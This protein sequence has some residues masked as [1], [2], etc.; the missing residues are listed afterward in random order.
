M[1]DRTHTEWR[2][3]VEAAAREDCEQQ[4]IDWDHML[5][6]Y[7][8]VNKLMKDNNKGSL[9][10][11]SMISSFHDPVTGFYHTFQTMHLWQG[12]IRK[13][14]AVCVDEDDGHLFECLG[15]ITSGRRWLFMHEDIMLLLFTVLAMYDGPYKKIIELLYDG[16]NGKQPEK[17]S[18]DNKA[19]H[20]A[21]GYGIDIRHAISPDLRNAAAH[22]SF[23]PNPEEG[24][25]VIRFTDRRGK[26]EANCLYTRE[27]L[28]SI[29]TKMQDALWLLY[30]AVL[31]WW[32]VE[33]GPMRLFDDA[34][35]RAENGKD[36]RQAALASMMQPNNQNIEAWKDIVEMTRRDLVPKPD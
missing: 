23:R 32:K 15:E 27:K 34:F 10:E 9:T 2:K 11:N 30:A 7:Q 8:R 4:S 5:N 18:I 29:Y 13:I 17:T 35:F 36:V 25:V 28:V 1:S 20:L 3:R 16:A 19:K 26:I 12:T 21:S 6:L 22:M 24:T 33:C 14:Q 31:Y